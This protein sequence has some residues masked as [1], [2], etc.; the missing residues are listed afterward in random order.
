MALLTC[1]HEY[2]GFAVPAQACTAAHPADVFPIDFLQPASSADSSISQIPTQTGT[3]ATVAVAT[4]T[5]RL[6]NTSSFTLALG[7]CKN[8]IS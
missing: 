3:H 8:L 5:H 6:T 1:M 7:C 4:V 2:E